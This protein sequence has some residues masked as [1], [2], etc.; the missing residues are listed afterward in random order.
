[1]AHTS[2]AADCSHAGAPALR[3]LSAV[4]EFMVVDPTARSLASWR[5]TINEK[6]LTEK[7]FVT[8]SLGGIK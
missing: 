7:A 2:A 8:Y 3:P 4:T 1:L 6:R 5:G